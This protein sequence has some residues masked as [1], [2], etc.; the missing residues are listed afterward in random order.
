[1]SYRTLCPRSNA[2]IDTADVTLVPKTP[3]RRGKRFNKSNIS[4]D[5]LLQRT[6]IPGE[7]NRRACVSLVEN[8]DRALEGCKQFGKAALETKV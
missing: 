5:R 7:F 2:D 8:D 3:R 4:R 6:I 1:M